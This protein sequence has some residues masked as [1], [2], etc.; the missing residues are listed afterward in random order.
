MGAEGVQKGGRKQAQQP[1]RPTV[2]S[3]GCARALPVPLS[4][5]LWA[6]GRAKEVGGGGGQ[7]PRGHKR[8]ARRKL[9][10]AKQRWSRLVAGLGMLDV[11]D[12]MDVFGAPACRPQGYCRPARRITPAG[13]CATHGC[14]ASGQQSAPALRQAGAY[15]PAGP[16]TSLL[17][18]LCSA[19]SCAHFVSN[20][21]LSGG[22][23]AWSCNVTPSPPSPCGNTTTLNFPVPLHGP[24]VSSRALCLR[25]KRCI[26][27][28]VAQ[29]LKTYDHSGSCNV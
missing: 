16:L 8:C 17:S 21:L 2:P 14:P 25:E 20:R 5:E 9:P 23:R 13:L 1:F 18:V 28:V 3:C 19:D 7:I 10:R 27:L 22:G 24:V 15:G 29:R 6:R 26:N 11:L 12:V 4:L